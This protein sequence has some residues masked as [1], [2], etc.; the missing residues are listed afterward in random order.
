MIVYIAANISSIKIP[1]EFF[2]FESIK[3]IGKGLKISKNL[4]DKKIIKDLTIGFIK[5]KKL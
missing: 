1:K 2:I 3:F 4:K 5:S